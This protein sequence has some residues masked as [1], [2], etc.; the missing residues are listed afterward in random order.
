MVDGINIARDLKMGRGTGGRH[1]DGPWVRWEY[2]VTV[3]VVRW[4]SI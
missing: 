4:T 3:L 1:Y 2:L